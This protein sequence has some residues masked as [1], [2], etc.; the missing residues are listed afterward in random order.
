M[1]PQHVRDP[2][3]R[4]LADTRW[5]LWAGLSARQRELAVGYSALVDRA[6]CR[7][8][9]SETGVAADSWI[10]GLKRITLNLGNLG[11]TNGAAIV[12]SQRQTS[13]VT[14][15]SGCSACY[16]SS[17]CVE[18]TVARGS[19]RLTGACL[20]RAEIVENFHRADVSL[21]SPLP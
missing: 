2:V 11:T 8:G 14:A 21:V 12:P 4:S 10:P 16:G 9:S 1:E 18:V 20:H 3:S 15:A 6:S 17:G 19:G 13:S 7:Q 5:I